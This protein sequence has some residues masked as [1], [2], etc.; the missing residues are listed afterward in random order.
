MKAYINML[1]HDSASDAAL[2]A[3]YGALRAVTRYV[4]ITLRAI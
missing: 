3:Y 2:R 1:R 4:D